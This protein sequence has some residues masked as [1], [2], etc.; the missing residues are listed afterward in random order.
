M[1]IVSEKIEGG[2]IR[3]RFDLTVEGQVVPGLHWSP[4]GEAPRATIL[5]GHGGFQS[6]EA[7]NIVAMAES[8][9]KEQR[10]ASIAL[11]A[12]RHGD[13]RT[14]EQIR[15]QEETLRRLREQGVDRRS[16]DGARPSPDS[17]TTDAGEARE[18]RMVR[19]WKALLDTIEAGSDLSASGPYGYWGVSMGARYGI[20]L[21]ATEPRIQ[22]AV[23]GLFGL[24]PDPTFRSQVESITIP[25]LFLFQY[26]DE[27][28]TPEAG[29]ALWEAFGSKEKTMH[30]NPG[31]HVGVPTFERQSSAA[32]FARHLG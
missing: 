28:M 5:F 23:F 15:Q 25:L 22:A 18:P 16:A 19:E 27:L 24:M 8:M 10:F 29:L 21:A 1:Q 6:K 26:H 20:P 31:P 11:D 17:S 13:R 3:R 9:A 4:E 30:I 12:P 32:F 14:D 7:P 2:V